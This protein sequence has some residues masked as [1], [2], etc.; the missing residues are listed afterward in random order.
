M[1]GRH[2]RTGR[3]VSTRGRRGKGILGD[4][5]RAGKS[6]LLQA[7]RGVNV[8]KYVNRG[9]HSLAQ[10]AAPHISRYI[11]NKL[12]IPGSGERVRPVVVV[13]PGA[14]GRKRGPVMRKPVVT[15]V[16]EP[17]EQIEGHGF[18]VGR[19]RRRGKGIF[20]S[21]AGDLAKYIPF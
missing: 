10:R 8:R 4:A 14:G 20:G 7:I 5:Y 17:G 9:I 18:R 15:M 3:F 12:G 2:P 11:T 16:G 21:I 13:T 19:G 6:R 1:V